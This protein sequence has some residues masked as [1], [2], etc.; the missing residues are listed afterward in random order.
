[1]QKFVISHSFDPTD[2]IRYIYVCV[3]LYVCAIQ[4]CSM[5]NSFFLNISDKDESRVSYNKTN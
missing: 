2:C 5:N 3:C 1:M 4:G